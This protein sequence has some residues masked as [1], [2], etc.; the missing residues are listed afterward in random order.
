VIGS[1]N[2]KLGETHASAWEILAG[3]RRTNYLKQE[4]EIQIV[5]FEFNLQ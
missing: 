4:P 1:I 2:P 5:F 3:R